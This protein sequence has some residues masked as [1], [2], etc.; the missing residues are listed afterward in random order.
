MR[1]LFLGLGLTILFAGAAATQQRSLPDTIREAAKGSE[2]TVTSKFPSLQITDEEKQAIMQAF[3]AGTNRGTLMK[4]ADTGDAIVGFWLDNVKQGKD[5]FHDRRGL[6]HPEIIE[7]YVV[8]KG[9]ATQIS[10]GKL[11]NAAN[12]L[13]GG[14]RSPTWFGIPEGGV[15]QKVKAGDIIL[16]PPGTVHYWQSFDS[17][18]FAYMNIWI[19]A[20]KRLEAGAINDVLKKMQK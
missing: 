10:G 1:K 13:Q 5:E 18:E 2:T 15:T 16:N 19:D 6:A 4:S 3:P 14:G 12:V 7:I 8:L 17:P 11:T 9:S 20:K